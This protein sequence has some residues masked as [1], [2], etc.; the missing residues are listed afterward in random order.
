MDSTAVINRSIPELYSS[1]I[2][3]DECRRET[4]RAVCDSGERSLLQAKP[5]GKFFQNC[6]Q[7]EESCT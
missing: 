6:E 7:G 4:P 1:V 5:A 2:L 3:C